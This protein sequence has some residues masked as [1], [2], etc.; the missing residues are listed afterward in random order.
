ML[1]EAI[2]QLLDMIKPCMDGFQELKKLYEAVIHAKITDIVKK[3]L[4][5][6]AEFISEIV[7]AIDCFAKKDYHGFGVA[8]GK[9]MILIFMKRM[10]AD[11]PFVEFLKGFLEGINE[12][13]D[14]NELMKCIKGGEDIIKKIID[15][16]KL[17]KTMNPAKVLEGVKMLIEAVKA[18]FE[19]IKP[20]MD[21]FE[22]LKKLYNAIIHANITEIV[23]KI[24]AHP[25]QFIT[26][27]TQAVEAFGKKD[28]HGAGKAIGKLLELMFLKLT[29]SATPFEEFLKGFLEGI[30]ETGDFEKLLACIK[31]GEEIIKKIIEAIKLIKTLN[32]I[33]VMEGVKMLIEA[34]KQ[35]LDLLKPCMEGFDQLKKLLEA[36]THASIPAIVKRILAH[37]AEFIQYITQA[38]EGFAK[39][40]YH[41]AGKAVGNLLRI[42]FLTAKTAEPFIEF[43][44]GFLEGINEKKSIDNLLKCLIGGNDIMKK[45]IEAL[46]LIATLKPADMARGFRQLISALNELHKML[47]P[48]LDGYDELKK[49]FDAI[50]KAK[51]QEIIRKII[52]QPQKFVAK[53]KEGV[54]CYGKQ[55]YKCFGKAF[56]ELL[57]LMFL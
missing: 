21:G 47:T 45:I 24:L 51:I 40:D 26:L 44:T 20:C 36:I 4:A 2:K 52:A 37:P 38:I 50:A 23:K 22:E 27:I 30:N 11:T 29:V 12:K 53:I 16:I 55:D 18:L 9:L 39:K 34:V 43:M 3:I 25:V 41:A 54:D 15:A 57:V 6:P 35:L 31:G 8:I 19:M 14:I 7:K 42:M 10:Q 5:H 32:P 33:K 17:I 46:K 28:Y 48:C 1:V 49:L 13:G 56:G